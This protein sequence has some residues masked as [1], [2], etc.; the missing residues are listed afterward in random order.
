LAHY[1]YPVIGQV[2]CADLDRLQVLAVLEPHWHVRTATMQKLRVRISNI[3]EYAVGK[4][5]R[6]EGLPD[7]A[8]W[9]GFKRLL[10][11]PSKIE[12]TKPKHRAALPYPR[13][14]EFMA[15]LAQDR[16]VAARAVELAIL[17]AA[18]RNEARLA[19]WEEIDLQT[20]TWTVPEERMKSDRP[21]KIPLSA[22]AIALLTAIK[23]DNPNPTGL[24]FRGQHGAVANSGMLRTTKRAAAKMSPPVTKT[25]LTTHGFRGSFKTWA[26]EDTGFPR[27][28]IDA[29]EG[30]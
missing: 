30:A 27:D 5:Y 19:V 1:A 10:T 13:M 11:K 26:G 29:T 21:H 14:K 3:I 15:A 16:W 18:R 7:P 6:P 12:A 17:T 25:D 22:G 4:K 9:S 24:V 8:A 23:G 28:V 2:R 20:R